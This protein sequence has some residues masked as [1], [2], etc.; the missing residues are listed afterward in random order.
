MKKILLLLIITCF[1]SGCNDVNKGTYDQIIDFAL[2]NENYK[3][4]NHTGEG[5]SF[6]LPKGLKIKE[7]NKSNLILE[8]NNHNYYLYIDLISYYN[9]IKEDY[10]EQNESFYSKS[11]QNENKFGYL[12]INLKEKNKY[13]IEFMYN[14]A[15]IEVIVD[16]RSINEALSYSM[17]VLSSID[18]NDVII[19]NLIG[20]NVLNYNELEVN[21]FETVKSD[22][23]FIQYNGEATSETKDVLPDTDL[24]N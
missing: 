23:N 1:I 15:K 10:K 11:I 18:Y 22:S 20:E 13:L 7:D 16:K 14:Y 19:E 21:I 3:F 9:K 12:E 2:A 4:K 5:Y 17:S 8:K 6:Y 24:I